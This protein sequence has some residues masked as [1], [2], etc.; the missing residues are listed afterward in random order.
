VM[1]P[2]A[3]RMARSNTA[4][5]LKRLVMRQTYPRSMTQR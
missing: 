3:M 1:V 2:P 4:V 5:A